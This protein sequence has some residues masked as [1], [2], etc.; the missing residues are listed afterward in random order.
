[1]W[2]VLNDET[3]TWNKNEFTIFN[4]VYKI[5]LGKIWYVK[6]FLIISQCWLNKL[7]SL[8]FTTNGRDD[9]ICSV[10]WSYHQKEVSIKNISHTIS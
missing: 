6:E 10:N 8:N 3:C 9:D 2:T 7:I 5:Y 4:I 1:M